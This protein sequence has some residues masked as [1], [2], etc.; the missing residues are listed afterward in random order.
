MGVIH[1][2]FALNTETHSVYFNWVICREGE[3]TRV[4]PK[5]L[6]LL[7]NFGL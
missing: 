1:V 7:P 2:N 5:V 4:S 3:E 6:F